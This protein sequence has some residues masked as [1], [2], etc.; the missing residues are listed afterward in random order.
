M[1][2]DVKFRTSATT[3]AG[4]IHTEDGR[5]DLSLAAPKELGGSGDGTNPEQLFAAGYSACFFSSLKFAAQ[6]G[7]VHLPADASVTADIGVGPRSEGGWGLV[8][9]LSV[10]LPG[11]DREQAEQ[12]I[13]T[14]HEICPYSNSTRNNIEVSLQVA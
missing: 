5:L 14:A 13:H 9:N 4:K 7:K 3:T 2:V 8:A 1:S 12:L 6:Q 10:K 11:V